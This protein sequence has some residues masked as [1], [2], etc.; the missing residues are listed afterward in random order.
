M[1]EDN[2]NNN[3]QR[4]RNLNGLASEYLVCAKLANL[5]YNSK[6]MDSGYGSPY[7]ISIV[8][9]QTKLEIKSCRPMKT[10]CGDVY[11][12][13]IHPSQ[14]TKG[15]V[16]YFILVAYK[17]KESMDADY[18]IVP[19]KI[20]CDNITKKDKNGIKHIYLNHNDL[21]VWYD[22]LGHRSKVYKMCKEQWSYLL[23]QNKRT[24]TTMKN[25]YVK[26]I[27]EQ[28]NQYDDLLNFKNHPNIIQDGKRYRCVKC[29][30]IFNARQNVKVHLKSKGHNNTKMTQRELVKIV[31]KW[32]RQGLT[33]EDMQRKL[34]DI[35]SPEFKV[36][37]YRASDIRKACNANMF[38]HINPYAKP[39]TA[40][41]KYYNRGKN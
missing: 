6:R 24:F 37:I 21:G 20:I 9:N 5:G 40:V 7:D 36:K 14:Y 30:Y 35:D 16:D 2:F 25:R 26:K 18:Y 11:N 29:N 31:P 32:W 8:S 27:Q 38:P 19:Q 13:N 15:N 4:K 17:D 3:T 28:F 12:F 41:I 39:R 10:D 1:A 23:Y 34:K 33:R 22:G